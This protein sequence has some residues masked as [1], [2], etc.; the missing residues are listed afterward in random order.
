MKLPVLIKVCGMRDVENLKDL[1][2]L[3]PDMIGFI[4]Y[5]DSPRFVDESAYEHITGIV[6]QEITKVGVFVNESIDRIQLITEKFQFQSIQ[7][8]GTEDPEVCNYFK[9]L[10]YLIIK[11]FGIENVYDFKNLE[12]Y[13]DSVDYFLLDSKSIL[14]GGSGK[15]FN[16]NLLASYP[17]KVPYILS[18][19]ISSDDIPLLLK[20][21]GNE[22]CAGLDINSRFEKKPGLKDIS[23]IKNF[24]NTMKQ[25]EKSRHKPLFG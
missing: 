25:N 4:F 11:A 14:K 24:I 1:V 9:E 20:L 21:I 8:H 16:W 13:L 2:K 7:L 19:G 18:G 6:P 17:F 23:L 3:R 22:A 15:K 12:P 5:P 10:N